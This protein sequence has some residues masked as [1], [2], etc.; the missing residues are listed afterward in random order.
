MIRPDFVKWSQTPEGIRQLSLKAAHPRTRERFQALYAIGTGRSNARQWAQ[1]THRC[2]RSILNW[3]H[4]YNDEGPDSLIYQATGGVRTRLSDTEVATLNRIVEQSKPLDHGLSGHGWT[5]KKLRQWVGKQLGYKVSRSLLHRLLKEAGFSW[6]KCKKILA[7]GD[8]VKKAIF[9]AEFQLW[10]EQLVRGE[11]RL[12]YVDESHIH[13]DMETGYRWSKKGQVDEVA[14]SSPGLKQRLNW[15][16]AY[17]FGNGQCFIWH[18]GKCNGDSTVAF[19]RALDEWLGPTKQQVIIIW[20]GASWHSRSVKVR[21][22]AKELELTLITLPPYSPDLNPIEGLWKWMR[23]EVTQH[24]CHAKLADLEADCRAFI[25]Q[26]NLDPEA[27][28]RRL[29]PKFSL[30]DPDNSEP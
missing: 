27:V 9:L 28:V 10:F 21:Q 6:K 5:L 22:Q 18:N 1:E 11:I 13:Q 19:L 26:I 17:D 4:R 23:E 29:W 24:F 3:I 14:S 25:E 16:G 12:I 15:Y 7:K 8:P 2:Q 20:D 30:N